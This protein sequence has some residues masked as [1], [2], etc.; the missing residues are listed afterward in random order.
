MSV[1]EMSFDQAM[2]LV[3]NED[4]FDWSAWNDAVVDDNIQ[5]SIS[6]TDGGVYPANITSLMVIPKPAEA[7]GNGKPDYIRFRYTLALKMSDNG[8]RWERG[9]RDI[10][11]TKG[12]ARGPDVRQLTKLIRCTQLHISEA[13][14]FRTWKNN[15]DEEQMT[16]SYTGE[17][18]LQ[19][20]ADA[21]KGQPLMVVAKS[22]DYVAND[23][24]S[25][26]TFD[27]Y[28]HSPWADGEIL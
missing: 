21:V 22:R 14:A 25:K 16:P 17:H 9:L 8:E 19:W 10:W 15:Q 13:D 20:W 28:A 11:V 5:Q 26:K 3:S 7:Q 18:S 27:F 23:G 1:K 24:T 12:D 6:M 2:G 4:Q